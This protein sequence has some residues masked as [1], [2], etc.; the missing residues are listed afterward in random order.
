MTVTKAIILV[1][2][3]GTRRLPIT[4]AVEKCMLPIGNRPI[5]DYVVED[6]IKAGI[7]DIY[8]VVGEQ[9]QQIR[10]YYGENQSLNDYLIAKGKDEKLASLQPPADVS[11]HYVT[12]GPGKYGTAVPV[13]LCADYIDKDEAVVVLGGD[14]FIYN[15]DGSSE[16]ARLLAGTPEGGSA[17]LGVEVPHD[18][19]SKYGV[20]KLNDNHEFVQIVEK[21]SIEEAPSQLINISKYVLSATVLKEILNYCNEEVLTPEYY[22]TEP[23]NRYVEH[24]GVMK[25]V[26][27]NGQYLDGGSLEGWLYANQVICSGDQ[28]TK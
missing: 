28:F 9:S 7:R 2:G 25:V 19:V 8:F 15:R 1:G 18:Q 20:L 11:F 3:W 14:D 6:C 22:I 24:G 4:K 17:M 27:A 12:Q 5:I 21:P 16:V 26:P 10:T 13:A 23:I